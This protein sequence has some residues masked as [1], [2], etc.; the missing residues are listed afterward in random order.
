MYTVKEMYEILKE[1]G[2]PKIRDNA[3]TGEEYEEW[4]NERFKKAID[5]SEE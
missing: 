4:R 1:K 2:M 5:E 3:I